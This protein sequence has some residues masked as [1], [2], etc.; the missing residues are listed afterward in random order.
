MK[1]EL[2]IS[3]N[4]EPVE[5][6]RDL[7]A[8]VQI[9]ASRATQEVQAAVIMAKKFPRDTTAA[10]KRIMDSCKRKALAEQA[11]YAYPKGGQNVTGPSI[12][13]AEVLAQNWGNL[14]FG[15]R[16]LENK[17]G[18]SILEAFCWDIETN[19]RQTKVFAVKHAIY[20]KKDGMKK[21]TDPRDI[22]E[23]NANNGAR[24]VR[25]CILGIIPGDIVEEAISACEETLKSAGKDIPIADRARSMILAFADIGVTQELI[26]KRLGHK[27]DAVIEQ[28]LVNLRKIYQSIKDGMAA[29]HDF[30]D[31]AKPIAPSEK[32]A[33]LT[34]KFKKTE[35]T[36]ESAE[37]PFDLGSGLQIEQ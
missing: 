6:S 27:I 9:E 7:P 3:N 17:N 30:F 11:M 20:T 37:T 1:N 18:E 28:E 13:M 32:A 24:R 14:D 19:V 2:V 31:I 8:G 29:R 23:N 33:E 35:K 36:F 34:A 22:Y 21:L 26:E 10:Y 4:G 5:V 12:R 25:A 15:I 16:E